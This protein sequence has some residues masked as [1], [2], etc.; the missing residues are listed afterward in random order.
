L[1][2]IAGLI[3]ASNELFYAGVNPNEMRF[4]RAGCF[5]VGVQCGGWGHIAMELSV[6]D[7]DKP[8]K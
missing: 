1:N 6:E 5:D 4:R 3:F 8:G 7:R 2:S